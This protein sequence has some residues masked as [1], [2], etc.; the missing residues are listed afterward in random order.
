[1]SNR[2]TSCS[3]VRALS[4]SIIVSFLVAHAG[5]QAASQSFSISIASPKSTWESGTSIRL[6]ITIENHLN[7][8]LLLSS[9]RPEDRARS[10]I[11][12][13]TSDGHHVELLHKPQPG[14]GKSG[15][16]IGLEPHES[17]SESLNLSRVFDLTKPGNYSVQLQKRD[18][19]SNLTVESNVITI[20]ITP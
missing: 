17:V 19:E 1:M 10:E 8:V 14:D 20:T 9:S 11:A 18:P 2:A 15:L 6:D 5:A 16:G 4:V 7:K 13:L 3:R 12:V